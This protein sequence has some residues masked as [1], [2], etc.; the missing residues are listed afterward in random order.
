MRAQRLNVEATFADYRE[1]LDR[2]KPDVV[3][4]G[5]R[6]VTDRVA[7]LQA[8]AQAGCHAYCEK[9]FVADLV[10]ADAIQSAFARIT[11]GWRWLI[12]GE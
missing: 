9:P 1:M 3:C 11:F 8:V 7:V 6:W 5:P 12:N 2:V 10:S 4:V